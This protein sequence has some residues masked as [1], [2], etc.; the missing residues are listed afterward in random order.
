MIEQ[1]FVFSELSKHS[2]I[3]H[4]IGGEVVSAGFCYIY[5]D[6]YNCYGESVSC[7]VT[8]RPSID[9]KILNRLLGVDE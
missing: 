6:R 7:K 3:A 9:D 4:R 1:P 2:D 5:K 8:S